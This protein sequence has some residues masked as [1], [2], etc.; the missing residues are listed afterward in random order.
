MWAWKPRPHT[1][2]E[3]FPDSWHTHKEIGGN[4]GPPN[5]PLQHPLEKQDKLAKVT[6]REQPE[7][8]KTGEY[9]LGLRV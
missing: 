6:E 2:K 5:A 4:A 9:F 7:N 8:R 3:T 1:P